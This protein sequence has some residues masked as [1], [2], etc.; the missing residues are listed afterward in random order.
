MYLKKNY[1]KIFILSAPRSGTAMLV[2]ILTSTNLVDALPFDEANFLFRKYSKYF[3]NDELP[4]SLATKKLRYF[5]ENIFSK[6]KKNNSLYFVEKTTH[7]TLRLKFLFKLYPDALYI[8]LK[9]NSFDAVYSMIERRKSKAGFYYYY[10]KF[11]F[12]PFEDYFYYLFFFIKLLFKKYILRS[13]NYHWGPKFKNYEVSASNK[14]LLELCARQHIICNK[15]VIKYKK[16]FPKKNFLSLKYENL[17]KKDFIEIKRL[18]KFLKINHQSDYPKTYKFI[19]SNSV[20]KSKKK[21]TKE[22]KINLKKIFKNVQ[23]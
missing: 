1:K 16:I 11:K 20:G 10:N 14:S 9:R 12:L 18:L 22:E 4:T 8:Y 19:N 2:K 21:F 5:L 6:V 23:I 13:Y 17:V 3:P 7:N 15:M